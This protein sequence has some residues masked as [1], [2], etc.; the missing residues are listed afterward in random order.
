MMAST[1]PLSNSWA[2]KGATFSQGRFVTSHADESK[3]EESAHFP[4]AKVQ[5]VLRNPQHGYRALLSYEAGSKQPAGTRS[6]NSEYTVIEGQV[7]I[8]NPRTSEE[9]LLV[10]GSFIVVPAGC[11]HTIFVDE[12]SKLLYVSTHPVELVSLANKDHED[13]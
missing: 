8:V 5:V 1:P 11:P 10:A 9:S 4:N 13:E 12:D 3:Q 6:V 7:R 2:S